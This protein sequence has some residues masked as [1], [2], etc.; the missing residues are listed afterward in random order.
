MKNF[1][2][3]NSYIICNSDFGTSIER[4][5]F[6]FQ[7]GKWQTIWLYVALNEVGIANGEVSIWYNGVNAFSLTNLELRAS[8]SIE[9]IG[10]LY[11][12]TFFGGYDSSWA[13]PSSQNSYFRNIRMIG[14][15]GAAN[16]TGQPS[17]ASTTIASPT[18]G[19]VCGAA[20]VS[21]LGLASY[22]F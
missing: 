1:C 20:L 6:G 5:S 8:G 9:S 21:V 15:L 14:G 10:G 16:G 17:A 4:S 19:A 22:L 13:S 3:Q 12:S 18:L 7:S 11:F 2:T